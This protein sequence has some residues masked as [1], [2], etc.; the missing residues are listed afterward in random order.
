MSHINLYKEF[1]DEEL[2]AELDLRKSKRDE[3]A[4]VERLERI[5]LFVKHRDVLTQFMTHDRS[6]CKDG[7]Y[8][9]CG[10]HPEHGGA[11]CNLCCLEDLEEWEDDIEVSIDIRLTRIKEKND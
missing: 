5:K 9:N 1:T 10:F 11:N 2:Q 6:S 7:E 3:L 4:K 8:S